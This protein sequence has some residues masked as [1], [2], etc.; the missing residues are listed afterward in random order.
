MSELIKLLQAEAAPH[1]LAVQALSVRPTANKRRAEYL[2]RL[3]QRAAD[4]FLNEAQRLVNGEVQWKNG[5]KIK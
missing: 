5:V 4:V 3:H 1:L 2:K